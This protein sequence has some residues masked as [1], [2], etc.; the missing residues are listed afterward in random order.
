MACL[1]RVSVLKPKAVQFTIKKKYQILTF[2]KREEMLV[3]WL[4]NFLSIDKFIHFSA[5]RNVTFSA[6]HALKMCEFPEMFYKLTLKRSCAL[7]G[8]QIRLPFCH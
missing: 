1:I 2:Q 5:A 6:A 4:I 8:S 3:I 7:P